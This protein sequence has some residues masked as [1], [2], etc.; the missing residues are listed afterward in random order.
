MT[1]KEP[2]FSD[3]LKQL[4]QENQDAQFKKEQE[5]ST[6]TCYKCKHEMIY[7][8]GQKISRQEEC[9]KCRVSLY[10]CKMC[11]FYDVNVYNECREP[12]AD[13][14]VEK[15]SANFCDY[16]ILTGGGSGNNDDK[17][18]SDADALFKN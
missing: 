3:V 18:K 6:V 8:V 16:F 15:E 10:C 9:G 4:D 17:A 2:K 5:E 14:I 7:E 11:T 12:S 13:R 1:E